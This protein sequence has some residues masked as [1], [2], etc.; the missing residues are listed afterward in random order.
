MT[1][2]VRKVLGLATVQDLGRVGFASQAVPRGG[3]L[4]RALARRANTAVGNDDH[5]AC[6][7]IFGK[8][9]VVAE[10]DVRVATEDGTVRDLGAGEELV[11]DAVS[12]LRAR[13]LAIAGGVDAPLVLGSR[14]S[15][16]G[17]KLNAG[18]RIAV[19]S[20]ERSA[21]RAHEA[22]DAAGPVRIVL[23]P[24]HPEAGR[25]LT[26]ATWRIA[27]SSD[28]AG[29]RLE[30]S[31]IVMT[32]PASLPSSPMVCGAIQLPPSGLPIVIGPD[33]PTTGG[34]AI[35]AVIVRADLDRL[36]AR[37]LGASIAF[38]L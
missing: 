26:R 29:T 3:A 5:A 36:H 20:G 18:D 11:I 8:L 6:I 27:P 30:G 9:V 24:D 15:F 19:R 1:L 35:V 22:L 31:R 25:A 7:E 32:M 33:G 17:A 23:G 13:Y 10:R 2:V 34:Y 38:A 16:L 14:S 37:P 4:V 12:S 21:G 28:R